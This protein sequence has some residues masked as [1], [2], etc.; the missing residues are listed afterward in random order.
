MIKE[1]TFKGSLNIGEKIVSI[2]TNYNWAAIEIETEKKMRIESLLP[3]DYIVKAGENKIL[4]VKFNKNKEHFSDLF[5]YR[6]SAIITKCK[7][8]TP[9]LET[10][11]LHI[12]K[13][14]LQLW[15]TLAKTDEQSNSVEKDWA[16][17]GEKWE[18]LDFNGN[19]ER[20]YYT[21][22]KKIYD[23][24]LKKYVSIKEKINLIDAK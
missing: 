19:N 6:G 9:E 10:I 13:S 21:Y 14:A 1:K 24:E 3:D 2:D 12:N 11:K 22:R 23:N 16:Y 15:N 7:I 18:D 5:K 20:Q 17:L 4:V 8:V